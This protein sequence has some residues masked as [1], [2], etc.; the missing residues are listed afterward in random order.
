MTIEEA[1]KYF[2]SGYHL[3]TELDIS[4]SN[5]VRWKKTKFIPVVQQL[6]IN[7]ITGANLPIDINIERMR[8]R[9]EK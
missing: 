7:E 2:R 1:M 4:T 9:I 5:M 8:K 6:K 3:C